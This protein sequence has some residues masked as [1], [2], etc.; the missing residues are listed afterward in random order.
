MSQV[1]RL[2]LLEA[3]SF[4]LHPSL[5]QCPITMLLLAVRSCCLLCASTTA[6]WTSL[7]PAFSYKPG[8]KLNQDYG[9]RWFLGGLVIL[10]S[11]QKGLADTRIWEKQWTLASSGR[12]RGV[13]KRKSPIFPM[14]NQW[15]GSA[16]HA[17]TA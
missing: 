4:T 5:L 16:G 10:S 17:A 12:R 13:G 6:R 3:E 1:N 11:I 14:V 9:I 7:W 2:L 8:G 15:V